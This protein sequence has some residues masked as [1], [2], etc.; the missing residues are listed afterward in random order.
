MNTAGMNDNPR[1]LAEAARAVAE[2]LAGR[3]ADEVLD[4]QHEYPQLSSLRAITLGTLRWYPRL[5]FMLRTL[6][7]DPP[8]QLKPRLAALLIVALHQLEYSRHRPEVCVSL[9]VDA[10][11]LI[12]ETR[13]AGLVNALL[14]R[15][16]RERDAL[17]QALQREPAAAAAHP[18]WL[19]KKLLAAWPLQ[20]ESLLAA[21]NA[22]GPMTLRL[23][24]A[25]TS[26]E[27][28]LAALARVGIAATAVPWLATALTL[29]SAVQVS[30]LPEFDAGVV[31]VQDAA[32]QLAAVLL[33]AE[34]GMRVLD[35]CAA[36]GGKTGALLER[37]QG[38]LELTA[39][40]VDPARVQLIADNLQRLGLHARLVSADLAA[41]PDWWDGQPFDRILL[42][43]PCSATG[44]IR[45][46]PDIK[47]LRRAA[48]LQALSE[49]QLALLVRCFGM[50]AP[51]GRLLYCTCSVLPEENAAV[52]A[53][54]LSEEPRAR[55]VSLAGVRSELG[56]GP[57]GTI[58]Q[59]TGLQ[60]L[61]TAQTAPGTRTGTSTGTGTDGFYYAC[62]TR[63]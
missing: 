24:L 6:A 25:R 31:S 41:A 55:E 30:E 4:A 15:F 33:A 63:G 52:V 46:H 20:L 3:A 32:A 5:Q 9:A 48:D 37:A 59:H 53:R 43:A 44:V 10:A 57:P 14:R 39:V 16:L 23:N 45:R 7:S 26:R 22:P 17:L 13:A 35:A 58:P 47:L 51:G 40:D 42:D 34:P 28:Y 11:R 62:L 29:D 38:E 12:G 50:L 49:R 21:N 56:T 61:P 60:I 18:E 54:F 27:S 19:Y 2:V 8:L 36:P 1:T